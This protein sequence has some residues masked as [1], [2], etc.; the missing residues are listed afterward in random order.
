[1]FSWSPATARGTGIITVTAKP[2][3]ARAPAIKRDFFIALCTPCFGPSHHGRG[4]CP[5]LLISGT[6]S[7]AGA[8][9]SGRVQRP[10]VLRLPADGDLRPRL[11]LDAALRVRQLDHEILMAADRDAGAHMVA[12]IDQ[13]AHL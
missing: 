4:R 9:T 12:E 1:M 8:T 13:L 3:T 7:G 2:A 10:A 6:A 5:S 11:E